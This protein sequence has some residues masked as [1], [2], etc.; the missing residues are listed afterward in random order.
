MQVNIT[1]AV[2]AAMLGVGLYDGARANRRAARPSRPLHPSRLPR[3]RRSLSAVDVELISKAEAR[4][5]RRWAKQAAIQNRQ[6]K[7]AG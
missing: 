6:Q 3:E 2:M 1:A 7:R 4:R 5:K